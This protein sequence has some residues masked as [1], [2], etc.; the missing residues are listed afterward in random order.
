MKNRSLPCQA[1][2]NCDLSDK[3]AGSGAA[4]GLVIGTG[5]K[6][7]L[8]ATCKEASDACPMLLLPV[9]TAWALA[10]AGIVIGSAKERAA[11]NAQVATVKNEQKLEV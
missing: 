10:I 1:L 7:V 6:L 8:E 2:G 11:E 3:F 5:V 4:L 9:A